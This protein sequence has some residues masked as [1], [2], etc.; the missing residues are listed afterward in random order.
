MLL[1]ENSAGKSTLMK[2]LS[3]VYQPS[4]GVIRV[5]GQVIGAFESENCQE[6]GIAIIHQ[7]LSIINEISIAENIFLGRLRQQG[8]FDRKTLEKMSA[9]LLARVGLDMD[10]LGPRAC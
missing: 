3:G 7:E 10:P 8:L 4:D 9:E 2:I 6:A 1:G 5:N